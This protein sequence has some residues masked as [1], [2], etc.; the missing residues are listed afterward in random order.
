MIK[1]FQE[2]AN[3]HLASPVW[4]HHQTLVMKLRAQHL[5]QDVTKK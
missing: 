2:A 3:H 1:G 4:G 5:Q